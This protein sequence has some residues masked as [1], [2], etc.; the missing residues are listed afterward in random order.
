MN[1]T[2]TIKMFTVWSSRDT[3]KDDKLKLIYYTHVTGAITA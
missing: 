1:N 2:M 3:V